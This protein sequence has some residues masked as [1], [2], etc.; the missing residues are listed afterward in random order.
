MKKV[1]NFLKINIIFLCIF[2]E[3]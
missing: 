1:S 2:W 3:W